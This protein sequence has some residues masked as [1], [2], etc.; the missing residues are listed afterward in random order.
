MEKYL[1]II[2]EIPEPGISSED[3]EASSKW[4]SFVKDVNAISDH[5]SKLSRPAKNVW[6]CLADNSDKFAHLLIQTL[7]KYQLN[8]TSYF[9]SDITVLNHPKI[10]NTDVKAAFG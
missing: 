10:I 4:F 2:V 7:A 3:P 1:L 6:L 8:Y 9:I 5:P